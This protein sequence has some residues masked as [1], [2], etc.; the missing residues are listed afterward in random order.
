MRNSLPAG[1]IA[2]ALLI[3]TGFAQT[4]PENKEIL[5]NGSLMHS[6]LA[7]PVLGQPYSAVQVHSTKR[8]LADGTNIA[9][10]GHHFIAR[11]ASGRV[12]V[13]VRMA[14]ATDGHSENILVFV[15]DPEVHTIS[16]WVTGP[17]ANK[18][19]T[20]AKIPD[21]KSGTTKPAPV[22][23]R[24]DTRPQPIITTEDLGNDIL[25]GIPVT[26]V[27]TT[28]IVPAGRSHNDA[29][30]TKSDEVWTSPDLKLILKEQWEDPR[31]GERTLSLEKISRADPD[32][33]LFRPPADYTVKNLKQS[34]QELEEKLKATQN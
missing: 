2:I 12:R 11:D 3:S 13:E 29:P 4:A 15:I 25:Q 8:Q 10:D 6:L 28:T 32:P 14:N 7:K 30:I 20:I 1:L 33:A 21:E 26:V 18:I 23:T 24:Q 5:S 22:Q 31:T 19:A 16:T 27:K 17:G 34:L 9:H